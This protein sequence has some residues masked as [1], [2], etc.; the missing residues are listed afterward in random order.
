M[1]D[2][3]TGSGTGTITQLLYDFENGD[4]AALE[5]LFPIV[6]EE[7]RSVA[8]RQRRA[9]NGDATMG[10][11][12]LVHEAYLKLV[13]VDRL[14]ARTR[15]HFLRVASMAMRQI[16]C[17]YARDQRAG[18]RGGG[19]QKVPLD[20]LGDGAAKVTFS[21]QQ[22]ETLSELDEALERLEQVDARLAAVVECR[23]FGGLT[24]EDTASALD[25]SIAT[26]KRDWALARSWLYREMKNS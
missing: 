24:I 22:S 11:T 3:D 13:D 7:L 10:T 20:L 18:K 4:R 15:V 17:N 14:G 12:A 8:H 23:F 25:V 21:E 16:L 19:A 2:Q 26:V 5:A 1:S 6:Y 9:W